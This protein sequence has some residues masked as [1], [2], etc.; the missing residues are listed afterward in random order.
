MPVSGVFKHGIPPPLLDRRPP[1]VPVHR[2]LQAGVRESVSG[3]HLEEIERE[4]YMKYTSNVDT[5]VPASSAAEST[6]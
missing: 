6:S 1:D 4:T 3:A 5:A 2:V